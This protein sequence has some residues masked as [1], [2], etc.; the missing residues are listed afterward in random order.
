[1]RRAR[2]WGRC[3]G[4]RLRRDTVVA[5]CAIWLKRRNVSVG[6]DHRVDFG[7]RGL[8][9]RHRLGFELVRGISL[10]RLHGHL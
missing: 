5:P 6:V 4:W 3:P 1:V 8:L 2:A 7:D 9:E 10:H